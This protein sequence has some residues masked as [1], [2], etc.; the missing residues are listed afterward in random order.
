MKKLANLPR[1]NLE[2]QKK[3]TD[4]KNHMKMNIE[5]RLPNIRSTSSLENFHMGLSIC[6]LYYDLTPNLYNTP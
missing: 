6:E 1:D 4:H 3:Y 2:F 5:S